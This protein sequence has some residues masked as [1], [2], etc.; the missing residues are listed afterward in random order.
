[1]FYTSSGQVVAVMPSNTPLGTATVSVTFNTQPSGA[2]S[3][4][5][6]VVA[7]SVGIFT[8]GA[9]GLGPGIFT[10]ALT[11]AHITLANPAAP[12][13]LLTGWATGVGAVGSDVQVP[14]VLN[15]PGVQVW[16]GGQ[17]AQMTYAGP[18]GGVALDQ[19]NFVVPKTGVS[20]CSVP[21]LVTSNGVT[22]TTTTIPIGPAGGPC[23]DSGPT[24]PSNLLTSAAAGTPL[25]VGVIAIAP[26]TTLQPATRQPRYVADQLS[27]ALHVPVSVEDA[28]KIMHAAEAHNSKA[29]KSALSKY[30][31]QWKALSSRAKARLAD[32]VGAGTAIE[33]IGLFGTVTNES[34]AA[35][36]IS[37]QI[38]AAGSCVLLPSPFPT[39]FD[40]LSVGLD[41]GSSLSLSVG[42]SRVDNDKRRRP[43]ATTKRPSARRRQAAISPREATH[44]QVMATIS[45]SASR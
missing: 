26:T 18:G 38:P 9:T 20:G 32:T 21:V 5:V 15:F 34:F 39:F 23:T 22:S 40:A 27:A 7:S 24:I 6:N 12:G 30:A 37:A 10:D 44:S 19:L 11:G 1:M 29:L 17:A 36:T 14:P 35:S 43:W 33:V 8:P 45:P 41:A 31:D 2:N 4:T 42:A 13:E 3:A 28:T 16:V 25:K